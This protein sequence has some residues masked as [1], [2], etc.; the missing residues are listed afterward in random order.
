MQE[1]GAQD[2]LRRLKAEMYLGGVDALA[3]APLMDVAQ[4]EVLKLNELAA[5]Q[6]KIAS[7]EAL[8]LHH[9]IAET[10]EAEVSAIHEHVEGRIRKIE[11]EMDMG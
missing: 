8:P 3:R 4:L 2:H 11:I 7:G 6:E 10:L 9:T 5:T 1:Q